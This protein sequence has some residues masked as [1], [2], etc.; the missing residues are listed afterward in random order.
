[1]DVLRDYCL[2]NGADRMVGRIDEFQPPNL[3]VMVEQF[4]GA[5]MDAPMPIDMGMEALE[6]SWTTSGIERG[7]YTAFGIMIGLPT[8]IMVRGG[9]SNTVTGLAKGVTHILGGKITEIS[10][11][12]WKPGERAP[13]QVKMALTFYSLEHTIPGVPAVLIDVLNGIRAI[14]GVDQLLQLRILVGR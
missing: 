5:G 11:G 1:M 7:M 13:L 3:K 4:R 6:A 2:F 9:A 10:P 8:T 12:P 14:D